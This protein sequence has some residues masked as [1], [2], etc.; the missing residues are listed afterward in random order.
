VH[1]LFRIISPITNADH[2]T[3][4][5]SLMI[6]IVLCGAINLAFLGCGCLFRDIDSH[7]LAD[8]KCGIVQPRRLAEQFPV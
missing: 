8:A 3:D 1:P 5:H 7:C 4:R 2:E 6:D